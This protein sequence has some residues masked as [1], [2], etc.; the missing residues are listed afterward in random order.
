MS[1]PTKMLNLDIEDV[2]LYDEE[3]MQP[4]VFK[5]LGEMTVAE[6]RFIVKQAAGNGELYT[7]AKEPSQMLD[8]ADLVVIFEF[9]Q[10]QYM[11]SQ[12]CLIKPVVVKM[13]IHFGLADDIVVPGEDAAAASPGRMALMQIRDSLKQFEHIVL[14]VHCDA[15]LHWTVL[16][17]ETEP[18]SE[19]IKN[20]QY[21]DWC[22]GMQLNRKLS[23]RLLSLLGSVQTEAGTSST[24]ANEVLKLP[25]KCN[26][27]LQRPGSNDCGFAVWHALESIFKLRRGEQAGA[28][29]DPIGWRKL[30]GDKILKVLKVAQEKWKAEDSVGCKP[31][32][33]VCL[34]GKKLKPDEMQASKLNLHSFFSCSSCRWVSTGA[35][36]CYCNPEKHG[37]LA[38][39]KAIRSRQL[40]EE[41]KKALATCG[42]LGLIELPK[43]AE[44]SGPLQG[45]GTKKKTYP[46]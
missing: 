18:G 34:P 16:V 11:Q 22:A 31:K 37:A 41:L 35:G 36:C 17:V 43:P 12:V 39:K 25:E 13:A 3:A 1:F 8:D 7:I 30:L 21:Y 6:K 15:P 44:S 45:G 24:V 2:V 5:S 10:W 40:A 14:P 46:P 26:H 4:K 9:L 28:K 42:E 19:V 29:P 38:E 20:V 23:Q 32:H 33:P 27:Y